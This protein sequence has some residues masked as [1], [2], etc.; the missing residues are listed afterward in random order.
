MQLIYM[1]DTTFRGK[2]H[3]D[4]YLFESTSFD[5]NHTELK[6]N[7]LNPQQSAEKNKVQY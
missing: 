5:A 6:G 4:L 3:A 7:K 2:K 1:N